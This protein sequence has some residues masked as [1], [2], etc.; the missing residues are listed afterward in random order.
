[1]ASDA[2]TS[3]CNVVSGLPYGIVGGSQIL[4][5]QFNWVESCRK[6]EFY[7][8]AQKYLAFL[9]AAAFCFSS[10]TA[11]SECLNFLQSL[12]YPYCNPSALDMLWWR[13]RGCGGFQTCVVARDI[14]YFLCSQFLCSLLILCRTQPLIYF[15]SPLF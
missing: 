5:E 13:W 7:M 14:S 3:G 12:A 2:I 4:F 6:K 1:M 10:K 9:K 15:Y 8:Y 11:H